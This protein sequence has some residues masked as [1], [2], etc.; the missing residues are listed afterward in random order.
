MNYT[1]AKITTHENITKIRTLILPPHNFKHVPRLKLKT[2]STH[3]PCESHLLSRAYTASELFTA[4]PVFWFRTVDTEPSTLDDRVR[5]SLLHN[6]SNKLSSLCYQTY[7]ARHARRFNILSVQRF[8]GP[9]GSRTCILHIL[10]TSHTHT[11]PLAN[12]AGSH[13]AKAVGVLC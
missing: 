12:S 1:F 5:I 10:G 4:E 3:T 9:K 13:N 11:R 8:R 6:K 7:T 2:N